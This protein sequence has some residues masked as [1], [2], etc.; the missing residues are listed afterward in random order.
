MFSTSSKVRHLAV[1]VSRWFCAAMAASGC[2]EHQR[3][4]RAMLAAMPPQVES[5][6][7]QDDDRLLAGG[8]LAADFTAKWLKWQAEERPDDPPD[9]RDAAR[10][11]MTR[12]HPAR[13]ALGASAIE[14]I[15][16]IGAANFHEHHIWVTRDSVRPFRDLLDT[17][18]FDGARPAQSRVQRS[19]ADGFVLYSGPS[20]VFLT[21]GDPPRVESVWLTFVDDRTMVLAESESDVVWMAATLRAGQRRLMPRWQEAAIDVDAR[22]AILVVR[23]FDRG[24]QGWPVQLK[25]P[26]AEQATASRLVVM[27]MPDVTKPEFIL[28]GRTDADWDPRLF[29]A[30]ELKPEDVQRDGPLFRGRIPLDPAHPDF[31]AH[32]HLI[33]LVVMGIPI[34]I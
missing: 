10:R 3:D 27:T 23:V 16:G 14:G 28:H 17:G 22:P 12:A 33:P 7:I 31:G 13:V 5:V 20:T 8:S 30:F 18:V 21:G 34:A 9:F 32:L 24:P 6:C 26:P 4:T 2:A 11:A 19:S 15:K 25:E 1:A 29:A